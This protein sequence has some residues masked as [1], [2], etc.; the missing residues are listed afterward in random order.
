MG[1][2][3]NSA[4]APSQQRLPQGRNDQEKI[5]IAASLIAM[6]Q[7]PNEAE[8]LASCVQ[9]NNL[10]ENDAQGMQRKCGREM[11]SIAHCT[12]NVN[13]EQIFSTLAGVGQQFCP[14]QS[15]RANDCIQRNGGNPSAC[16]REFVDFMSCSADAVLDQ[17]QNQ[18]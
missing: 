6:M 15:A 17:V 18:M 7:C 10:S 1:G 13:E 3:G 11:E 5:Q 8:N 9:R 16:E 14:N 4:P 2:F 12:Q